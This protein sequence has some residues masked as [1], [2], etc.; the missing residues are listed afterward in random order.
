MSTRSISGRHGIALGQWWR[1]R[2]WFTLYPGADG[3]IRD[4]LLLDKEEPPAGA[5]L[6]TPRIG[7]V[8][9]GI[10]LGA[11]KVIHCGAV[12]WFLPRGPVEEVSLEYFSRGRRV[13]VRSGAPVRFPPEEVVERAR[14]RL[15]EDQY[16]ILKNNCEHLCEWCLRGRQRSYQVERLMR[17]LSPWS[18]L[19]G[20]CIT[21]SWAGEI[22]ARPGRASELEDRRQSSEVRCVPARGAL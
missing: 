16:H 9:H 5:H 22:R 11:G 3:A 17:W 1:V 2:R 20:R 14:S 6:V 18:C 12:S 8:H 21:A 7:F 4:R 15:G 13:W 10:Y 19:R